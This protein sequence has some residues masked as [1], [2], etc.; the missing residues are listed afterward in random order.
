MLL[1]CNHFSKKAFVWASK[2]RASKKLPHLSPTS[3][4]AARQAVLQSPDHIL[5]M[6]T[7]V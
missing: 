6:F 3:Q 7:P 2:D 5:S 1:D 4:E